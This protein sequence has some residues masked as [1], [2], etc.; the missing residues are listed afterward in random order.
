MTKSNYRSLGTIFASNYAPMGGG[1]SLQYSLMRLYYRVVGST[2]SSDHWNSSSN[3][4]AYFL[5]ESGPT[6]DWEKHRQSLFAGQGRIFCPPA[7]CSAVPARLS[8]W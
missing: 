6:R 7:R 5:V 1:A 2:S 4:R 8:S 3:P